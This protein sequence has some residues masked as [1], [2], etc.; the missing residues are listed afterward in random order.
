MTKKD[1][2]AW[3]VAEAKQHFSAVLRRAAEAPQEILNR[4]R[5]IA[6]IVDTETFRT[7]EA[8]KAAQRTP[9]ADSFSE[10]RRIGVEEDYTLKIS[11]R[12]NRPNPFPNAL[13]SSSRRHPRH[14]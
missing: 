6:T 11:R 3:T 13:A 2:N 10:L 12:K 5:P 4:D 14:Q 1:P 7:F 9:I 8:W